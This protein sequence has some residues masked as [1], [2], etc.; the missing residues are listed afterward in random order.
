M[1][2][3]WLIEENVHTCA[4]GVVAKLR[5]AGWFPRQR[6]SK[7]PGPKGMVETAGQNVCF[8]ALRAAPFMK[9]LPRMSGEQFHRRV[10]LGGREREQ[11]FREFFDDHALE[12]AARFPMA[13]MFLHQAQDQ[14]Q[15]RYT[16]LMEK[17]ES[18]GGD[19]PSVHWLSQVAS[20]AIADHFAARG[21]HSGEPRPAAPP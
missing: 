7:L 17:W 1:A 15:G 12:F 21:R 18:L 14:V 6:L 8:L 9:F 13:G 10:R 5:P 4:S 3:Q 2:M 19:V 11:V 16:R 20:Y